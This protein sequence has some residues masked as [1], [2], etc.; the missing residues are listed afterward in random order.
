M[1]SNASITVP[2][3]EVCNAEWQSRGVAE[4][5]F[6]SIAVHT[7]T[8]ILVAEY[9]TALNMP[10]GKRICFILSA[11]FYPIWT[12]V[13]LTLRFI[14]IYAKRML[15]NLNELERLREPLLVFSEAL[16]MHAEASPSLD[17]GT[18]TRAGSSVPYPPLKP[19][20]QELKHFRCRDPGTAGIPTRVGFSLQSK[21]VWPV[22]RNRIGL[23]AT[24]CLT[25]V[26]LVQALVTIYLTCRRANFDQ[27]DWQTTGLPVV[28]G[29][30]WLPFGNLPY[31]AMITFADTQG[32]RL[33]IL[34]ITI[35]VPYLLLRVF[36]IQWEYANNDNLVWTYDCDDRFATSRAV[37]GMFGA[38]LAN[39]KI[40][41]SVGPT[42][43]L[44]LLARSVEPL[45]KMFGIAE[46]AMLI[47]HTPT[48]ACVAWALGFFL[49]K[50]L[51][52]KR[53]WW[54]GAVA[55]TLL[56]PHYYL[57]TFDY[58]QQF[59][60]LHFFMTR[61]VNGNRDAKHRQRQAELRCTLYLI[62]YF[63]S[64]LVLFIYHIIGLALTLVQPVGKSIPA[65]VAQSGCIYTTQL[66]PWMW[67]DALADRL[68][69]F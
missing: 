11:T 23:V 4:I 38:L 27:T 51:L 28:P 65:V 33:S 1:Q 54:S 15:P 30:R 40:G 9:A 32:F 43:N 34:G 52:R 63:V 66:Y 14:T 6:K 16:D 10:H 35:A 5:I 56:L 69:A 26:Y 18:R 48:I 59:P 29:S 8:L 2:S 22:R 42:T 36:D 67:K 57:S 13:A 61:H 49:Q 31:N 44:D 21:A 24:I 60:V 64:G 17:E 12:A 37:V 50:W 62:V 19:S 20:L 45:A 39:V 3:T 46:P 25:L 47:S 7:S 41:L 58:G 53:L 55:K 68:W